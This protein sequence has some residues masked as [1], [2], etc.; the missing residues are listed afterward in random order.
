MSEDGAW[1]PVASSRPSRPPRA[2]SQEEVDRY[3]VS[4]LRFVVEGRSDRAPSEGLQP[5]VG[6]IDRIGLEELPV[7]V[8]VAVADSD[9][10]L[11]W[12]RVL[13]V[14]LPPREECICPICLASPPDAPVVTPCGHAFCR[15]CALR[16]LLRFVDAFLRR[17]PPSPPVSP[18]APA[19]W[20][21]DS[22]VII[23]AARSMSTV[24]ATLVIISL[25]DIGRTSSS[26]SFRASPITGGA[27]ALYVLELLFP[28]GEL[29]P[30][31]FATRI[32][33]PDLSCVLASVVF[34]TYS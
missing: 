1:A 15:H 22:L 8:S 33:T 23:V 26:I 19:N 6:G 16:L 4:T 13:E 25:L 9:V 7:E 5:P 2:L 21:A 34:L 11:P 30:N 29:G 32:C 14:V 27:G 20:G 18:P 24:L 3:I 12:E 31:G 17:P 28:K 10:A